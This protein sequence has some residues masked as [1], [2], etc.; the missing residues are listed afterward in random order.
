MSPKEGITF[1]LKNVR[2]FY[3]WPSHVI[4]K[5][6]KCMSRL[7]I[8]AYKCVIKKQ[9]HSQPVGKSSK[10]PNYLSLNWYKLLTVRGFWHFTNFFF[11]NYFFL[12]SLNLYLIHVVLNLFVL[13]IIVL[14]LLRITSSKHVWCVG[15]GGFTNFF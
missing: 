10:I 13:Y 11:N 9:A 15:T 5:S 8:L 14:S 2:R 1:V 3:A 12:Q 4:S 6:Y 7:R